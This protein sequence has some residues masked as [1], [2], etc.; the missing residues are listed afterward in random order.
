MFLGLITLLTALAISGISAYYSIIGLTAIFAAAGVPIIIM[1]TVLEVGKVVTT[2]WLHYNWEQAAWKIKSYLVA[3]VIILMLIT[4]MGT[5]GYLSKAHLDQAVP[6]GDIQAK[7][8]LFDEKIKTQRDNIDAARK[9][10]SQM[11]GA[12]DQMLS[13]TTDENGATKAA[14]LRRSQGK[15]RARLQQDIGNAQTEITKLQEARVPV[16]ASFRKVE[17]E[18]GPI[19][20]IAALIYGN[21]PNQDLLE[22]AV[23]WVI[24]VI[25]F[26]FDPLAIVLLLAATTSIDWARSKKERAKEQ[27]EAVVTETAFPPTTAIDMDAQIQAAMDQVSYKLAKE[28]EAKEEEY[29]SK[30]EEQTA[31]YSSLIDKLTASQDAQIAELKSS[32]QDASSKVEALSSEITDLHASTRQITAKYSNFDSIRNTHATLFDNDEQLA[33]QISAVTDRFKDIDIL[34]KQVSDLTANVI[35]STSK[36]ET[37]TEEVVEAVTGPAP[38]DEPP[39]EEPKF[40]DTIPA[41][42][43]EGDAEIE[44]IVAPALVPDI[45]FTEPY[46][47][48]YIDPNLVAL[49]IK[50]PIE[51]QLLNSVAPASNFGIAFPSSPA[52]GDLFLRVDMMPSKLYKWVEPKWIEVSKDAYD[53]FSYDQEYI[54][55]LIKQI[56]AGELD[57]D[58]CSQSEQDK[59]AEYLRNL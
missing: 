50:H 59:I 16:A 6:S 49:P 1:G 39:F 3:A 22:S 15:E 26:V 24:I 54:K 11:D 5:F 35:E 36:L 58:A 33:S 7:V 21:N 38:L 8:S 12:V 53:V 2:L 46:T 18:V 27:V 48:P 45:D 47:P 41:R 13:R 55:F 51:P 57:I 56:G 28:Y 23:R 30:F 9:A 32:L 14:N 4:S 10:L 19:K 17:A 52:K 25:V 40:A 31:E 34:Q 42:Y 20:Y 43:R 37:I 29:V 44:V